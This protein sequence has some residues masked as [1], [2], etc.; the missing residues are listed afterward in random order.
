MFPALWVMFSHL[1]DL[2]KVEMSGA[3]YIVRKTAGQ[4][5]SLLSFADSISFEGLSSCIN[6]VVALTCRSVFL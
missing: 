4:C 2:D 6:T 5:R 1:Y 3:D